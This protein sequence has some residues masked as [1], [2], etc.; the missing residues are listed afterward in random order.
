VDAIWGLLNVHLELIEEFFDLRLKLLALWR[1]LEFLIENMK[2]MGLLGLSQ[3]FEGLS[4]SLNWSRVLN[5]LPGFL[6][7]VELGLDGIGTSFVD[8]NL[9]EVSVV[10]PVLWNIRDLNVLLESSIELLEL[11]LKHVPLLGL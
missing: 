6:N 8:L 4:N 10:L 7:I 5:L 1:S 2:L 9:E 11:L 3:F